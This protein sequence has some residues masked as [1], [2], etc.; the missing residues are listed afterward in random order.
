M[1]HVVPTRIIS[2]QRRTSLL[3]RGQTAQIRS[4]ALFVVRTRERVVVTMQ[5]SS[6]RARRWIP[7]PSLCSEASRQ[8][9][10]PA[11]SCAQLPRQLSVSQ[12]S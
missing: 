1:L 2:C 11:G 8:V 4:G 7:S 10:S 3:L 6:P 5:A 12:P 9:A